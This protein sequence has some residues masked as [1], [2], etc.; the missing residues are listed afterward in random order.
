MSE[1]RQLISKQNTAVEKDYS[2]LLYELKDIL[3][4]GLYTAYKAVDN[5][6]VQTYWQIGERI[7]REE[8]KHKD[9][10]EYGEYIV[11]RLVSDLDFSRPELYKIIKFYRCY[12]I[13]STVSR[14][15][16]WSH[17]VELIEFKDQKELFFYQNKAI[18]HS[19]SVRELRQ[20]IK[21]ELYEKTSTQEI[22]KALQTKLP[23]VQ[24]TEVF[25]D[26]YDFDFLENKITKKEKDLEN[27]IINSIEAFLSELGNDISFLGRQLPIKIDNETHFIDLVLYHCGIPC[28]ILVDLKIGKI[29]SEDIG[30]MNKYVGYYQKNRQYEH[31]KDTI[32]LI[33]GKEAG[34]EEI[35]YALNKLEKQIFIATYKTKLPSKKQIQE[36]V[37]KL[38]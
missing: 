15:L 35:E 21:N 24:N 16:S 27:H 13:V 28:K 37:R 38:T 7:V 2:N 8:L 20:K 23:V 5:I 19:W 25:K 36:A 18:Q 26:V 31:E 30:Q 10:A 32:G 22:E 6:K 17:Y 14:Q 33:I 3:N 12:E 34:K 1:S 9:R 29:T 4:K 11:K